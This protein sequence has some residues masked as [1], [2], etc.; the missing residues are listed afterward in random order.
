MNIELRRPGADRD[1]DTH[2][3]Q[4]T[5]AG[6][7]DFARFGQPGETRIGR[8]H[9]VAGCSLGHTLGNSTRG[10]KFELDRVAALLFVGFDQLAHH[11]LH[12]ART[13]YYNLGRKRRRS[14]K[15]PNYR[16]ADQTFHV[17]SPSL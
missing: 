4:I 6:A 16:S 17:I 15:A 14:S 1:A 9:D 13:E 2:A 12:G 8:N 3:A 5:N 11:G 7:V 10:A